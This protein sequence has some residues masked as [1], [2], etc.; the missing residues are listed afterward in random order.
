MKLIKIFI[1][2]DQEEGEEI[3]L[4]VLI[5]TVL[6]HKDLKNYHFAVWVNGDRV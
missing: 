2:S 6:K 5:A 3:D 1:W 4:V